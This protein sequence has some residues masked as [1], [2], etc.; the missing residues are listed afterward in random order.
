M[1]NVLLNRKNAE[2]PICSLTLS[3]DVG[4]LNNTFYLRGSEMIND[5]KSFYLNIYRIQCFILYL[6]FLSNLSFLFFNINKKRL[7]MDITV[8]IT[9]NIVNKKYKMGFITIKLRNITMKRKEP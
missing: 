5:I 3:L 8:N 2:C 7:V 4:L 6:I 9:I 1:W